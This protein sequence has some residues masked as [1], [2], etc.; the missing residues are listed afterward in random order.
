[1]MF[2]Q[3]FYTHTFFAISKKSFPVIF[4]NDLFYFVS[5]AKLSNY[6]DDNQL[7]SSHK[8]PSVVQEVLV[9]ELRVASTWFC[10]YGLTLNLDKCKLLVVPERRSDQVELNIDGVTLKQLKKLNS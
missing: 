3:T 10:Y 5:E 2:L 8:D 7:T 1:M 6:A 9:R 4:L